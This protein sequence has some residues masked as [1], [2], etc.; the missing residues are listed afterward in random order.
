MKLI[1]W[2]VNGIRSA[3]DKGLLEFISNEDPDIICIQ[4]TK[5]QKNQVEVDLDEYE[6]FW[7][8]AE[9]KGYSGTAIFT[10]HK[11]ISVKFDIDEGNN[12]DMTDNYGN[13]NTEGRVL[14]LELSDFYLVNVYTPNS[15]RDLSRLDYRQKLWDPIFLNYL[16][17]L[18]IKKPVIVC[19]DFNVAHKEIDL[20]N[21]KQNQ[22]THGFT[23]EER[24]GFDKI[25]DA[26]FIDTFR[27]FNK[28]G[29]KYTWWSP[30]RKAR[31]R[32]IGWRIDYFLVSGSIID[33]V[34]KAYILDNVPG[35]DHCPI[36]LEINL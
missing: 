32:N 15:K 11:P 34:D 25:V 22:K 23:K 2:N 30:F 28:E 4:E 13:G 6:E 8:S 7:N 33:K 14:T 29:G 12:L 18:N 16:K 1:S 26:G 20:A 9:R 31:E 19:G 3:I 27:N 35:S 5:A 17:N 36:G 21:P 24:E 10:K